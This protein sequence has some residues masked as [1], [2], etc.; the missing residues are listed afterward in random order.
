MI[1]PITDSKSCCLTG[2]SPGKM[3]R[4]LLTVKNRRNVHPGTVNFQIVIAF[5]KAVSCLLSLATSVPGR[6]RFATG[7][8]GLKSRTSVMLFAASPPGDFASRAPVGS[9]AVA[10]LACVLS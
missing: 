3:G 6:C 5:T 4:M 1:K 9:V 8:T 7:E 2:R 10:V